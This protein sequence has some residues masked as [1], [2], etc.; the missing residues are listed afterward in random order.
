MID[1]TNPNCQVTTHFT[2][3]DCLML[4][5][6]NRL[7][8]AN[9][10]INFTTITELANRLESVRVIL[11]LSLGR[12]CSMNVHCMFRSCEYN[13]E[14]NIE[15]PNGNDVHSMSMACD[16]DCNQYF[17]IAQV[18]SALLPHLS[19]LGIRMEQGTTTWVH[20]DIHP[21]INE[22]YFLP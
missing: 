19:V 8:T 10:G 18:K 14:Q 13:K 21:V 11:S 3:N 20:I 12:D 9:D 1:W 6:W 5:N 17:T 4:H 22:R 16:F 15:L 2:V 7:A